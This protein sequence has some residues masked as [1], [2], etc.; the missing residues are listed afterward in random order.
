M[1]KRLTA[2]KPAIEAFLDSQPNP[3]FKH[4][5]LAQ[6]LKEHREQW[7]LP[8]SVTNQA[9]LK[10]LVENSNLRRVTIDLPHRPETLYTWGKVSPL[11]I[12]SSLKPAGYLSH[13]TAM[14]LHEL[15]DQVPEMIYVNDEQR[16]QPRPPG[17]LTQEAVTRAFKGKQRTS[18]N[19]A[20]LGR[21]KVC[22]LNGK[23]TGRLGV[24]E[25]NDH[26]GH[27][28]AVTGLERTLIDVAVRPVYSGGA[29]EV[30]EAY[31]RAADSA[32]VNR[33]LAMLRKIDYIYPYEQVIGFYMERSGRYSEPRLAQLERGVSDIDF[34]LT[35]GMKDVEY[36]PRWKLYFPA[37][38]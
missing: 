28:I 35:Y 15:T 3:A 26:N 4:T 30:L 6:L 1:I 33:L 27:P 22:V 9:L 11:C 14:Q 34:Y 23:N 29:A 18:K 13:Y 16:P 10:Y 32:Q 17:P 31:R 24:I 37:G 5:R 8:E 20:P 21:R 25:S 2:A 36:S 19:I 38:F 7:R 12:A